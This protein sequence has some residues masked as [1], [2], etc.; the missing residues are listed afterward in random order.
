MKIIRVTT[1]LGCA[2]AWVLAAGAGAFGQEAPGAG[3]PALELAREK[4][5]PQQWPRG[6]R[7]DGF[8]L[9]ELSLPGLSG[10]EVE[11][12]S[13]D[14][15]RAYADPAGVRRLLVEMTVG[16]GVAEAHAALLSH[17]AYVQ[18]AKTLATAASRG[19]RAGDAGYVAYGGRDGSRIAWVAF[20]VGNLEFRVVNLDPDAPGSPDPAPLVELLAA[21]AAAQ[22]ALPAGE[23]VRKPQ[24]AAFSA[25]RDALRAGESTLLTIAATD[26]AGAAPRLDFSVGGP[27]QGYVELDDQARWRFFATGAGC[28]SVTLRVLGRNGARATKHLALEITR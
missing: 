21:R 26:P 14:V 10:L 1:S 15:A 9:D 27:G 13:G 18:S 8:V 6:E 2:L 24:V 23:P 7:R 22:P 28:A 12:R 19:I 3:D 4:Y 5:A 25:D 17:L 20:V 16:E 11:F